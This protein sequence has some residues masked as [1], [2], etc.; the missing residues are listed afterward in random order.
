MSMPTVWTG[1][2][3]NYYAQR[4]AIAAAT[5]ATREIA[6]TMNGF[7]FSVRAAA[8]SFEALS[9]F[10]VS[11]RAKSRALRGTFPPVPI[12]PSAKRRYGR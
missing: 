11:N 12:K 6:V 9:P 2:P 7:K 5:K 4:R 3:A 10:L 8:R 1:H